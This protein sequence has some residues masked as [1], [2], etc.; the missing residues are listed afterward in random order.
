MNA[1]L[2]ATGGS[3]D[4]FPNFD[5]PTQAWDASGLFGSAANIVYDGIEGDWG[6]LAGDAVAG[7]LDL[8]GFAMDPLGSVLSG[9]IG[10]LIEH[11]GFLKEPL[12]LLAGDADAVTAMA[13]TWTNIATRLHETA[14]KYNGSLDALAGCQGAAVEG[15]RAAVKN[16]AAVASGGASHAENAASAM[17][18]AACVVG[19]V[20]GVIRDA[21][22]QFAADAIIKFAAASALAPVTFG[23]SEAAFIADE[24]AEGAVLAGKNAKKVAQAVKKLEK[25]AADAKKSRDALNGTIKGL[26]KSV[27]KYNRAAA[28]HANKAAHDAKVA[29]NGKGDLDKLAELGKKGDELKGARNDAANALA[30]SRKQAARD[31]FGHNDP[32]LDSIGRRLEYEGSFDGFDTSLPKPPKII[33]NAFVQGASDQTHREADGGVKQDEENQRWRDHW[34]SERREAAASQPAPMYG[35]HAEPARQEAPWHAEGDLWH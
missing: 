32:R 9:V 27:G 25:V 2:D 6:A 8:L 22:S 24:V 7:G 34:E 12:D 20:R 23:A 11:I 28:R 17:T 3:P 18:V 15:Y 33:A 10:W 31:R 29:L 13:T 30:K 19:V 21:V 4:S 14:D 35:P 26:D 16:F 1:P 5:S